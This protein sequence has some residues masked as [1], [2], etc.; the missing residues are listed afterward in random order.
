MD[1]PQ[2]A[3]RAG[4]LIQTLAA[5]N[6]RS[7]KLLADYL[8]HGGTD[9]AYSVLDPAVIART[10]QD[11]GAQLLMRPDLILREQTAFWLDYVQLCTHHVAGNVQ[12][13]GRTRGCAHGQRQALQGQRLGRSLCLRFLQA[14]LPARGTAG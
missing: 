3:D 10:F 7:Q 4:H 9:D 11:M 1:K 8:S 13:A 2:D 14:V 12:Q 5:V 6:A